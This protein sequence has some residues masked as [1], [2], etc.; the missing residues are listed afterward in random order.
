MVSLILMLFAGCANALMDLSSE[1]R[2]KNEKYNKEDSWVKKWKEPLQLE[3]KR[4]YYFGMTPKYQEK[5]LYS[6][7]LFVYL[8]DFWHLMK[9]IMMSLIVF[10]IILYEPVFQFNSYLLSVLLNF[11]LLRIVFGF[12]F[13]FLYFLVKKKVSK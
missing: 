4:W 10:S 7:T 3:E 13:E 8:T 12:G 11:V 6:S 1:K 2:F 5:F 9:S